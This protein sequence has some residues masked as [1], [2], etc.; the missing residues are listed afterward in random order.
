MADSLL[1]EAKQ[2]KE[3]DCVRQYLLSYCSLTQDSV[4]SGKVADQGNH[5]DS[6][7]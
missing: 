2:K 1:C 3:S 4:L 6:Y 5:A 7:G